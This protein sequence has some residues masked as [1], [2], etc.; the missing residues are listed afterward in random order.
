MGTGAFARP[1]A[2]GVCVRSAGAA[3]LSSVGI[4]L[5]ISLPHPPSK[6]LPDVTPPFGGKIQ[7]FEDSFQGA[8][9]AL[10]RSFQGGV[11]A[12]QFFPFFIL[13]GGSTLLGAARAAR[14]N[15]GPSRIFRGDFD[16]AGV[17]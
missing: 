16:L 3:Q 13:I 12:L 14:V 10:R 4:D 17:S 6:L 7:T 11:Q 5:R 15:S 2:R 1:G 8:P 9:V